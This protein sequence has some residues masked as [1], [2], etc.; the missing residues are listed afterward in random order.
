VKNNKNI[1]FVYA[2]FLHE[3]GE[4][5]REEPDP[6][7]QSGAKKSRRKSRKLEKRPQVLGPT[8]VAQG[9]RRLSIQVCGNV[10]RSEATF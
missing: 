2:G 7:H 5:E 10:E 1:N 3:S 4:G 8:F 9:L 6:R